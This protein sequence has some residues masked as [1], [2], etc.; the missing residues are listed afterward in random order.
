ML[1]S[2]G[3][4]RARGGPHILLVTPVW[5]FPLRTVAKADFAVA[6]ARM[7]GAWVGLLSGGARS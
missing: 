7:I 4:A 5:T 2:L 3:L 1:P 6:A